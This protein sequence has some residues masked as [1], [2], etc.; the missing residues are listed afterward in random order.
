MDTYARDVHYGRIVAGPLVRAAARRHLEDR[1]RAAAGTWRFRFSAAAADVAIGFF[2]DAL[3]L[4]DADPVHDANCPVTKIE[5]PNDDA[6]VDAWEEYTD[7]VNDVCICPPRD[8]EPFRLMPFQA[9]IVGSC[10]GWL[11]SSGLRRF[12]Y[13]LIGTAKGSGKTPLAAGMALLSFLLDG[14]KRSEILFAATVRDQASIGYNDAVAIVRA[15]P[16]LRNAIAIH[17][18]SMTYEGGVIRA[19]S[20]EHRG[21]DGK[22]PSFAVFDELQEHTS[23]TVV[24]KVRAGCKRRRQ[25]ML[26]ELWNSGFDR[27]SICYAHHEQARKILLGIETGESTFAYI[28]ALDDTDK[29]L[30]D[31]AC[32][33]KT[34][35]G[36][37]ALPTHD[38]L[39]E[40]VASAISLPDETNTVLRLNFCIWTHV[41]RRA[42]SAQRITAC[43]AEQLPD[44][45]LVG[46]TCYG[47]L[48]LGQTDDIAA[49]ARIW[50][51]EDG[52]VA[53][54]VRYWLPKA[55]V[56]RFKDRPYAQWERAGKLETTDGNT[57]DV[58]VIEAAI[59]AEQDRWGMRSVGYDKRFANTQAIH[60]NARYGDDFAVDTP[61]GFFLNDAI[62]R[63][64]QLVESGRLAIDPDDPILPWMLD[65]TVLREGRDKELRLDKLASAQKI[66]GVAALVMALSRLIAAD[67]HPAETVYE[68]RGLV[69]L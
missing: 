45:V 42:F 52:R 7:A 15:S 69:A 38:Y 32:W 39:R 58:D 35:P 5:K 20:S 26:V 9:F 2:E 10:F 16:D 13:V 65:N 63:L 48:D 44:A 6:S 8:G 57:T 4:P 49:F 55:S 23:P 25:P 46:H 12:R 18:H 64:V 62:R 14:E 28:C 37:P 61:Q 11:K 24:N 41:E 56:K 33:I 50:D 21:L 43:A 22:R 1:V 47:G 60:L 67:A 53:V 40:Q 34:N 3:R 51:L 29:P 54:R 59:R 68:E 36:L 19:V 17:A 66:D 27:T 30:E 31:E